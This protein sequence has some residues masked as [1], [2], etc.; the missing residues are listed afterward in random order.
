MT[1]VPEGVEAYLG[2]IE[3]GKIPA[4]KEQLQL[5]ALVRKA[6]ETEK[7]F[8]DYEKLEKYLSYQK[9]FTFR[10]FPWE[11]FVFTL[12]NA[13]FDS[14]GFPR[15]PELLIYVGR[16]SGKN[17][18]L[19][20][21]NFCLLSPAH[22]VR[23]YHIDACANSEKQAKATFE[24]LYNA[25]ENPVDPSYEKALKQHWKWDK[26]QIVSLDTGSVYTY[27]TSNAKTKDGLKSGK[28]D[29]D[30]IHVYET[31]AN[32]QVFETGLGK[33]PEPRIS[34]TTT[35]GEVNG[36]VL[37][38]MLDLAKQA[39][40]GS[41]PDN[42]FLP[43]I[44]R[45]DD[46]AEIADEANW[47]K[48]NPSYPY[49]PTL[50]HEMQR[51]WVKYKAN[52]GQH[53]QFMTKR[54]NRR[55]LPEEQVAARWEDIV[56][57]SREPETPI[58][59]KPCILG[60]DFAQSTDF[61]SVFFLYRDK[62]KLAGYHHSWFCERSSDRLKIKK[63]SDF[64]AFPEILTFVNDVEI[65]SDLVC[66]WIRSFV[67][68]HKLRISKVALDYYR[69]ELFSKALKDILGFDGADKERVKLVRPNDLMKVQP[70]VSSVMA[71][72]L[73]AW[74]NDP[75]MR[76]YANNCKLVPGPNNCFKFEKIEPHSRKTDGFMAFVNTLICE[77]DLPSPDMPLF[78]S[79]ITV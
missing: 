44:C 27:H 73:I 74:G 54:M 50:R 31:R 60:I 18:Y 10:L 49:L 48:A 30:E 66:N 58:Y 40:S 37:D 9:Y 52:P 61:V 76:W 14:E 67:Q 51:E 23:E 63:L 21:E 32:I 42:G 6:F 35:D 7:L 78:Y 25:L 71:N 4:C 11:L 65:H 41:E 34:Y 24:Y 77:G 45:L 69:F 16:G 13:V 15:W 3:S 56:A 29:L 72:Q 55:Q 28:V 43:F 39:L 70:I 12:H 57:A 26:T 20:F 33:K 22:G 36:G 5:A 59:G 79:P 38:E 1:P 68:S 46:E 53:T 8:V 19:A 47:V 75:L 62:G 64:R 2:L 17:G